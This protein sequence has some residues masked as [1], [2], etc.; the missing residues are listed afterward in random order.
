MP[1]AYSDLLLQVHGVVGV[2]ALTVF[3]QYS[4]RTEGF[5][6]S[7]N[8]TTT[9]LT[10][11]RRRM[12]VDLQRVL[13]PV[14]TSPGSVPSPILGPDGNAIND[15]TYVETAVN[16]VGSERFRE[17]VRTFIDSDVRSIIEYRSLALARQHW[18]FWCSFLSRIL[19]GI[20]LWQLLVILLLLM[21]KFNVIG[22]PN[23]SVIITSTLTSLLV[24]VTFV[25]IFVRLHHYSTITRMRLKHGEL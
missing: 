8:G 20:F 11:L 12:V 24:F 17:C 7:L 10:E 23:W 22:L 19:L 21:D 25:V 5:I 4:D 1:H 9:V 2:T 3:Y 18:C 14:F 15:G 16:P 13:E 6:S